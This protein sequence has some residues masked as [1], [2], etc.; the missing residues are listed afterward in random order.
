M[1]RV[2]GL[3]PAAI[4][5]PCL[6]SCDLSRL[7]I[8]IDVGVCLRDEGACTYASVRAGGVY[9]CMWGFEGGARVWCGEWLPE[10]TRG[11]SH[12]SMLSRPSLWSS[13]T[14]QATSLVES[15]AVGFPADPLLF[16]VELSRAVYELLLL[17]CEGYGFN[18]P[19]DP[20]RPRTA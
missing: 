19:D 8:Y 10:P 4:P 3:R 6:I 17:W 14:L 13:S 2:C 16:F 11:R 1:R 20:H 12:Q 9:V 18:V 15:G 7:P 5:V